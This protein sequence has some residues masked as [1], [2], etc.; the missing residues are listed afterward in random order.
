MKISIR[1]LIGA[2]AGE[3]I[4]FELE[5]AKPNLADLQLNGLK[6]TGSVEQLGDRWL[7]KG[8]ATTVG[9]LS[10]I[11][12]L[13]E[14]NYPVEAEFAEE[15]A[16]TP[17]DDQFLAGDTELV[18]DEMLRAV[19]LLTVPDRPLHDPDCKGLC[20]VCGKDLNQEPHDH[21]ERAQAKENPFSKL[22]ETPE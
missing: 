4:P 3:S 19:I 18:L 10:C 15:F 11:R 7:V 6:V 21:P 5:V 20:D 16:S 1:D 2:D 9:R 22:K 17:D 12:C 14:F 13:T 8:K